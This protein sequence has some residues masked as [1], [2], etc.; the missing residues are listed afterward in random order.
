MF[1]DC[2]CVNR[3]WNIC[4]GIHTMPLHWT[5]DNLYNFVLFLKFIQLT[6]RL[7]Q[8]ITQSTRFLLPRLIYNALKPMII[9]KY[10]YMYLKS[11]LK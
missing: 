5:M 9:L 2:L 7:L 1:V 11:E 8:L 3:V 6:S 10:I 4:F